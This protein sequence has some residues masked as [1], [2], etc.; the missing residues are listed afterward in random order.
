[1]EDL[2]SLPQADEPVREPADLIELVRS[3]WQDTLGY[4]TF[5][6]DTGFFDAGGD[7]FVL[8]SLL[9]RLMKSTG[10]PV[11]TVDILRAPTIRSQAALLRE[12]MGESR[13]EHQ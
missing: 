1:M 13:G 8:I 5:S 3:A 7:S 4:D 9:G 2:T 10:L 12:L 6:D 11:K